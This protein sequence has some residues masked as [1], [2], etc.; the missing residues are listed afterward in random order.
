[1]DTI[2]TNEETVYSFPKDQNRV[3]ILHVKYSGGDECYKYRVFQNG[4][5]VYT[6][7]E[8]YETPGSLAQAG[9]KWIANNL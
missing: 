6:S 7:E 3:D 2:T 9:F 8:R 4:T 5:P 1:M